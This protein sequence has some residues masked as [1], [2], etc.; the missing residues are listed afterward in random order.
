MVQRNKCNRASRDNNQNNK[1][2]ITKVNTYK[3]FISISKQKVPPILFKRNYF[4]LITKLKFTI[5][6]QTIK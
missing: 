1:F 5:L 4:N 3:T 6:K 2:Q